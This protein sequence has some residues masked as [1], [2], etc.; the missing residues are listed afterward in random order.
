M[1]A[2]TNSKS[3]PKCNKTSQDE[4]SHR[5]SNWMKNTAQ[6]LCRDDKFLCAKFGEIVEN[7][8]KLKKIVENIVEL[9]QNLYDTKCML[10]K[11]KNNAI[12]VEL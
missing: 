12:Y 9:V 2:D 6:R 11:F 4:N 3:P 10:L 5:T 8:G 1:L 7:C